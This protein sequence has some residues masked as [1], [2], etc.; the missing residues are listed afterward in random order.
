MICFRWP[1]SQTTRYKA[2]TQDVSMGEYLYTMSRRVTV[3]QGF[4]VLFAGR[5][6]RF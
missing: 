5:Y 2:C 1:E 6:R 3:L 4:T